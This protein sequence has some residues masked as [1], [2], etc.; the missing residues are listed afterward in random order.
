MSG[1]IIIK[2][3]N[4]LNRK[5]IFKTAKEKQ[6]VTYEPTGITNFITQILNAR[7]SWNNIYSGH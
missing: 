3:L 5:R 4:I 1:H 2:T 6:Q 7:R